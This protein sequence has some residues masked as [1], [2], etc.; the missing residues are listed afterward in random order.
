MVVV[1]LS[2]VKPVGLVK[3]RS[4]MAS[5]VRIDQLAAELSRTIQDYTEDVSRSVEKEVKETA[6][7]V[8]KEVK[9]TAPRRVPDYYKHFTKKDK[10]F[11]GK[12]Q[13][14]IWNKKHYRRVHL[15]E[16]GHA[17]VGARGGRVQAYPHLRPAYDKHA[18]DMVDRIKRI[19]QNGG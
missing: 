12:K 15:L 18:E 6:D 2:V 8:L 1:V 3:G 16:F 11:M 13:Y 10:S 14:L 5:S 19:I 9:A 4:L 17:K 7:L